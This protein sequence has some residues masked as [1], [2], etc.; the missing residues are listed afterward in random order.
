MFKS[1]KED[2]DLAM[3]LQLAA[4]EKEDNERIEGDLSRHKKPRETSA[5]HGVAS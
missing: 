3:A 2:E 5:Y 4:N 1:N